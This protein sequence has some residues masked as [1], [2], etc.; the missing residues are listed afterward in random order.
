MIYHV[1]PELEPFSATSGG[2]ITHTVADLMRMDSNRAVV[3]ISA[4]CT[5]GFSPHR[6]IT[7][8]GL[9]VFAR[10]KG[11]RY[12]PAWLTGPMLRV[13]YR[14]FLA[15]LKKGDIVWCHNQT[16]VC[17]ALQ[18]GVHARGAKIIYHSHDAWPVSRGPRQL[19]N[20][21]PDAWIFV[22]EALRREWLRVLP[23][24]KNTHVVHNGADES[25]FYPAREKT[26]DDSVPTILFVG[27]LHPEKG[28]HVLLD[29]I[30]LLNEKGLPLKC[31]I[32]GSAF[33]GNSAP[34]PYVQSLRRNAAKNVEFV[35]HRSA[36]EISEEFRSADIFCCPSI[37]QE[38]FGK[39]NIEAM[40]CGIPVAATRVG[41]IEEIASTGGVLLVKPDC[42]GDLADALQRLLENPDLRATLAEQGL[43]SFL[44]RFK[45]SSILSGYDLITSTL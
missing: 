39:V 5:W 15:V 37:W 6:V 19:R 12:Y 23:S 4:D 31:R 42:A 21:S 45:W 26:H 7:A 11:R 34:T 13:I 2:A 20:L 30:A 29:S 35:G 22:S 43:K 24:L 16:Q 10:L 1:L 3:C 25:L 9:Q 40:A 17:A 36:K 27:R 38:P 32:V 18:D 44:S 14:P 41:G 28:V 33:S 8:A